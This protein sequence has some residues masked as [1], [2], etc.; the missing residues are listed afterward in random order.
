MFP[1]KIWNYQGGK[2]KIRTYYLIVLASVF[3]DLLRVYVVQ[4]D[5]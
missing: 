2:W 1:V 3:V 5:V 4:V